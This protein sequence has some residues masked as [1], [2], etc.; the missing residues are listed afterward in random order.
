MKFKNTYNAYN[1]QMASVIIVLVKDMLISIINRI[2]AALCKKSLNQLDT[3][4]F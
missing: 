4:T 2:Q 1:K 3:E